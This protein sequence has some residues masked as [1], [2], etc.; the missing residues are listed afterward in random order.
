MGLKGVKSF[1]RNPTHLKLLNNTH[2]TI[3]PHF[4]HCH[5][6]KPSAFYNGISWVHAGK[7]D[8]LHAMGLGFLL[9]LSDSGVKD[10]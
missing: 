9:A 5:L 10:L 1:P 6:G 3:C 7:G 8:G 4:A 2:N